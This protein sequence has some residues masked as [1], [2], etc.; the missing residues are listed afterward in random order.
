MR[1]RR[2]PT[3]SLFAVLLATLA[4]GATAT[5][6]AGAAA[7]SAAANPIEGVWS[8]TGGEVAIQPLPDGKFQGIVVSPTTFA[9]CIHSAGEVMWTSMRPQAD[10]SF[11][12]LHQWFRGGDKCEANPVLGLTAW[13]VIGAADGSRQ[14]L[15]CFSKPGDDSQPTIAPDGA[16]DH[17]TYG[18]VTSNPVAPLPGATKTDFASVVALPG[19]KACLSRRS[20]KVVLHN[21]RYDPLK[22]VM[23]RVN[24]R[25]VATVTD[26]DRLK[27]AIRLKNLP[28]GTFTVRVVATTVLNERISGGRT[29]RACVKGPGKIRL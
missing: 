17:A 1:I 18:C 20:L 12:G 6:A 4:L 9:T 16:T 2:L 14:L 19:T 5:S 10:G 11:W 29:Y 3:R 7:G 8:F 13:R 21:P 28:K 23:I 27:N 15:V 25:K 22:Q 24:G 26:P